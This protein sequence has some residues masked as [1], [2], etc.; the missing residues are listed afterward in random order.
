MIASL[1][2][3]LGCAFALLSL[4]AFAY[5]LGFMIRAVGDLA[6]SVATLLPPTSQFLSDVT[7]IREPPATSAQMPYQGPQAGAVPW[8]VRRDR[9]VGLAPPPV[10]TTSE[11]GFSSPQAHPGDRDFFDFESIETLA[12]A[13]RPVSPRMAERP[14][15]PRID[16]EI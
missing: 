2:V 11:T 1:Y 12:Q 8:P 13:Q 5:A 7:A 15:G 3:A 9:G 6:R 10:D 14:P 4:A 16:G